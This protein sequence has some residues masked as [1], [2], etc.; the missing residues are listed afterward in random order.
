MDGFH[1][2]CRKHR[3]FSIH[4]VLE[5][6]NRD[7]VVGREVHADISREEVID[8]A[9]AAVLGRELLRGYLSILLSLSID[10]LH[11]LVIAVHL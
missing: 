1:H 10:R 2:F 5:E 4:Q 9:L 6:V 8:L 3:L 11:W 7:V